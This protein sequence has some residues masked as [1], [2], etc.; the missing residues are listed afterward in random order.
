MDH[1]LDWTI[2]SNVQLDCVLILNI[3]S[4]GLWK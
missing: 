4:F 3:L 1:K 2:E